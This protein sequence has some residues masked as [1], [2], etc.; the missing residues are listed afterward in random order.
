MSLRRPRDVRTQRFSVVFTT[1]YWIPPWATWTQS[2]PHSPLRPISITGLVP[3]TPISPKSSL[4]SAC[5][6]PRPLNSPWSDQTTSM[7][8]INIT[9]ILGTF[10]FSALM[11]EAIIISETSVYSNETTRHYIQKGSNLHLNFLHSPVTFSALGQRFVFTCLKFKYNFSSTQ[12]RKTKLQFCVISSLG[13]W[14]VNWRPI[15]KEREQ[16]LLEI[17]TS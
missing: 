8:G 10:I 3:S 5:N 14:I 9:M 12:N 15:L 13:S 4:P 17:N 2:T 11:M 16:P 7:W 6:M 1:R